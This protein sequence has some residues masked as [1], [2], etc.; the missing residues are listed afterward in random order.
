MEHFEELVLDSAQYRP[1]LLLGYV[2]HTFV[3][4]PRGSERLQN[5]LNH[6]NSLRPSIQFTMEIESDSAILFL[7][8]LVIRKGTTLATKVYR[9]PT[10][11]G[12]YLNFRSNHL[13]HVKR[14][15]IQSL[16]NRASTIC[17]ERHDLLNEISN[18][19][20][21]FQLNGYPQGFIDSVINS[22]GSSHPNTEEKPLGS[23]YIPHVKGVSE[24]F[25]H[26]GNRYNIRMIVKT[27]HKRRS[28]LI[29]KWT[30]ISKIKLTLT[31]RMLL[32]ER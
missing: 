29:S 11:T 4:W 22:K 21:D 28:S 5:F 18:L 9:K 24:K 8:V 19:K 2:D 32:P 6:L 12:R 3:V 13:P 25:K 20:H 10:H 7:D 23:V 17:Q 14:G 1:S 30:T 15:L 16:H 31:L 27:K 26:I